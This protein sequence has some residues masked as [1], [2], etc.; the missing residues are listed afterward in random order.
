[1]KQMSL[2]WRAVRLLSTAVVVGFGIAYAVDTGIWGGLLV[3]A[4]V[5]ASVALHE[6]GHLLG[7]RT[8]GVKA[9][10]FFVGLGPRLWS[11]RRGE[12]EVGVKLLPLGGHCT[13]VGMTASASVDTADEPRAFRSQRPGVQSLIAVAGPAV[14]LLLAAVLLLGSDVSSG[15]A[16]ADAVRGFPERFHEVTAASVGGL[17]SIPGNLPQ[18]V[19]A[20]LSGDEVVNPEARVLSPVGAARL[21]DQAADSGLSSALGVLALINLFLALFN[22]LPLPPLDGGHIALAGFNSLASRVR[23]QR[24]ALDAGHL[25]P[26]TAVVLGALAVMGLASIALDLSQPIANPF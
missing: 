23:G 26:V 1:M 7:A 17:V 20:S 15:K 6:L 16:S 12:L 22:L 9:T 24:V 4:G 11:R 25:M 8:T 21:A 3:L 19:R 14:N 13:I 18:M 10:E 2:F 5:I